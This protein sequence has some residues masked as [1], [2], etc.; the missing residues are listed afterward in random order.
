MALHYSVYSAVWSQIG[1]AWLQ[2]TVS[3]HRTQLNRI[4]DE[5][6]FTDGL[7]GNNF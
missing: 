1:L 3:P 4:K 5:I 6:G 2:H 7:T